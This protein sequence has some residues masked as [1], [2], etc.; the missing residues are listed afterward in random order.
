MSTDGAAR[1]HGR[2][3]CQARAHDP[4]LEIDEAEVTHGAAPWVLVLALAAY[5]DLT[6]GPVDWRLRAYSGEL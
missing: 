6:V 2:Q 1:A 3:S 5:P 4:R